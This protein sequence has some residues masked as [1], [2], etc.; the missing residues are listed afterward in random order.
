MPLGRRDRRATDESERFAAARAELRE[1]GEV[2]DPVHLVG[3]SGFLKKHDVGLGLANHG[4]DR[5]FAA[6]ASVL[7]V[8]RE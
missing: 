7:D 1:T 6:A 2:G 5:L 4:G 3:K 8:V